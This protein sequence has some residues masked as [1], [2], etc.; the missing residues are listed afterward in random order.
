MIGEMIIQVADAVDHFT[1]DEGF[2]SSRGGADDIPRSYV[3]FLEAVLKG[4]APDGGLYVKSKHQPHFTARELRR[5]VELDFRERSLRVLEKWIHPLD[6]RPQEIRKFL[7]KSYKP[8]LFGGPE[9]APIRK[10]VKNHYT[11]ELFH[12]PTASF[13]DAA[14]QLMPRFF[15]KAMNTCSDVSK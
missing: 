7:Y 1:F 4:L 2:V 13:K 11:L 9:I 8:N 3:S 14:L 5:L 10:L 6:L 15:V 12:G